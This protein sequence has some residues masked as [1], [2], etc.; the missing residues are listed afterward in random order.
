MKQIKRFPWRRAVAIAAAAMMLLLSLTACGQTAGSA[1]AQTAPDPAQTDAPILSTAPQQDAQSG[2]TQRGGRDGERG[3][4]GQGFGDRRGGPNGQTPPE[5][6]DG[7]MPE[8]FTPP[9]GQNPPDG[10]VIQDDPPQG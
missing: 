5:G 2:A 8:G 6:F 4:K 7:Q 10:L 9:D 1:D 3:Q